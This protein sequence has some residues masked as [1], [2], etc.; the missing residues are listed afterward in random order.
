MTNIDKILEEFDKQFGK[1]GP[2]MNTDSIGRSAGCDDCSG[3]IEEREE[4]KQFLSDKLNQIR[5]ETIKEIEEKIPDILWDYSNFL[6]KWSYIDS[7][8]YSEEPKAVDRYLD[9]CK[10]NLKELLK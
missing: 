8:Y 5:Q 1:A 2:E 10:S 6:N 3:N 4:H 7:D 9:E